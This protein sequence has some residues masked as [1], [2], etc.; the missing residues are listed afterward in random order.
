MNPIKQAAQT[1]ALVPQIKDIAPP[2]YVFPYPYWMVALAIALLLAI[3]VGASWLIRNWLKNRPAP[4]PHAL[5][6]RERHEQ[7]V[8][9]GKA[10]DFA[11]DGFAGSLDDHP[12]AYRHRVQR[13]GDFNH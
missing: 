11:R 4:T 9:A 7:S 6:R 13:P 2:V 3:L 12:R 8:A 10:Y 5:E 1:P